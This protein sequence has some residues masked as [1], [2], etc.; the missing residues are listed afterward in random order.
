MKCHLLFEWPLTMIKVNLLAQ[1]ITDKN[2]ISLYSDFG[3]RSLIGPG[4]QWKQC[5]DLS[6]ISD[7]KNPFLNWNLVVSDKMSKGLAH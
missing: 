7:K 3:V 6:Q 4:N 1:E 2:G 5:H